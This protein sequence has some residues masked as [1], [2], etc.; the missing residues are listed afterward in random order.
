L[1]RLLDER[2]AKNEGLSEPMFYIGVDFGGTKIEA[3]AIGQNGHY[4]ARERKPNPGA[5]DDALL[6]IRDLVQ[7]VEKQA[8]K[9]EGYAQAH[10]P[11]I[12]IGAPGSASPKTGVIRNANATWLNGRPFRDDLEAVLGRPVKLSN[13]A[14]CLA[15][16]EAMDG[17]ASDFNSVAA[18]IIGTGCG[19]GLVA[20]NRL[21]EGA[22]GLAGEI[23]HMGLPWATADEAPGPAC[24]CGLNGCIETWVSGTGFARDFHA[25]SGRVLKAEEIIEAMRAGDADAQAAFSRFLSRLGRTVATLV[26][27]FDPDVFVFGGGLSNVTEIYQRLPEYVSAYVFS[28]TYEARLLQARWGDASGVRGAAFLWRQGAPSDALTDE[29]RQARYI[30]A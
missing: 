24:W 9:H 19:G 15:L 5:Y 17:A 11:G 25:H 22:H 30:K 10:I 1:Y 8:R 21:I 3:A 4:L 27:S 12:G 28:D 13:D 26:N 2:A 23:G 18:I 16:S 14:N 7:S 20:G 29:T 6:T